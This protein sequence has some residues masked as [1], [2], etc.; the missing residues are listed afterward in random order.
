MSTNNE[1]LVHV[2][3][4]KVIKHLFEALKEMLNEVNLTCSPSGIKI[5]SMDPSH[6]SLIHVNLEARSF[7]KYECK[8]SVC[9]GINMSAVCKALNCAK[10]EDQLSIKKKEGEELITFVFKSSASETV[11]DLKL[12]S[13]Q[14]ESLEIPETEYAATIKMNSML[15]SR[16]CKE[17]LLFGESMDIKV[18]P[19]V[20]HFDVIGESVKSKIELRDSD[21]NLFCALV[22][23]PI[24]QSFSLKYLTLFNKC[25]SVSNYVHLYFTENSPLIVLFT[26][27]LGTVKYYLAPKSDDQ[28]NAMEQDEQEEEVQSTKKEDTD[29]EM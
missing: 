25:S 19:R 4:A 6:V 28:D 11:F 8:K 24:S 23:S 13:I 18:L 27:Y 7:D 15:F 1:F 26:T 3:E 20:G 14:E 12:I 5:Q 9:L 22:T 2:K 21:L 29:I 10:N 17:G 16:V